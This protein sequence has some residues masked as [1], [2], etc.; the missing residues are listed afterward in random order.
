MSIKIKSKSERQDLRENSLGPTP[1]NTVINFQY[2]DLIGMSLL[3]CAYNSHIH[4]YRH[5]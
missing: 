3:V 5:T 4:K 2:N 1:I